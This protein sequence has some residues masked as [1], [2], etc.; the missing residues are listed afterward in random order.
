M[1]QRPE[2][3]GA[4][5][6]SLLEERI[7]EKETRLTYLLAKLALCGPLDPAREALAASVKYHREALVVLNERRRRA[8][9]KL[10]PE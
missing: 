10:A 4:D 3:N 7:A 5:D 9:R 8:L 1:G 2:W 6:L